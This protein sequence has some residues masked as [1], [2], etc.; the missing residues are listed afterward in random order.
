MAE[1]SEVR[2][3][4]CVSVE[5]TEV[6]NAQIIERFLAR[7]GSNVLCDACHTLVPR[8][9]IRAEHVF[10]WCALMTREYYL[11]IYLICPQCAGD[12]VFVQDEHL[13]D[14][15]SRIIVCDTIVPDIQC[16]WCAPLS[17]D[18][19]VFRAICCEWLSQVDE[20]LDCAKCSAH[21]VELAQVRELACAFWY[22]DGPR[23]NMSVRGHLRPNY[24]IIEGQWNSRIFPEIGV[25][26]ENMYDAIL[27]Y[28]SQQTAHVSGNLRE[29]M[30][31]Y[32][33]EQL[34]ADE[35][36]D[37]GYMPIEFLNSVDYAWAIRFARL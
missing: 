20:R 30:L 17:L 37:R 4:H 3:T 11:A 34:L 13:G 21:H 18:R 9:I 12:C 29:I 28:N 15:I 2:E 8:E 36:G 25:I 16:I 23:E 6:R 26:C 24:R 1:R 14:I 5:R 31:P 32:C 35:Y 33:G 27:R 10:C 19:F 22:E 7:I